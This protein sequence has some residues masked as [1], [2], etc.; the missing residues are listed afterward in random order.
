MLGT[1]AGREQ[2]EA[3]SDDKARCVT[4]TSGA[5]KRSLVFQIWKLRELEWKLPVSRQLNKNAKNN[6]QLTTVEVV[7]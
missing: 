4:L 2:Q 6:N 3:W 5:L 7:S 1:A